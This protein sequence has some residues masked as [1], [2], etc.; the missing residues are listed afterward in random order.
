MQCDKPAYHIEDCQIFTFESSYQLYLH[1]FWTYD[2][3]HPCTLSALCLVCL[4]C[5]LTPIFMAFVVRSEFCKWLFFKKS[6]G[7]V[8]KTSF[9]PKQRYLVNLLHYWMTQLKK[10]FMNF[11]ILILKLKQFENKILIFASFCSRI[12]RFC[13]EILKQ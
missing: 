12:S 9:L 10:G 4:I 7:E 3:Y 2:I 13:Q 8:P 5:P 11:V 1:F 6:H